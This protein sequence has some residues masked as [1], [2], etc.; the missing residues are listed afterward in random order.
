MLFGESLKVYPR[1]HFSLT[2]LNSESEY[3]T[4][5]IDS[6]DTNTNAGA[7]LRRADILGQ[8]NIVTYG[9][10]RLSKVPKQPVETVLLKPDENDDSDDNDLNDKHEESGIQ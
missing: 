4:D 10:S 5:I 1:K 2:H 7:E 9:T 8:L 6:D 3:L